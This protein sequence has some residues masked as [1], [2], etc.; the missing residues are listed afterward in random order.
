MGGDH[1]VDKIGPVVVLY[2]IGYIMSRV[3]EPAVDNNNP[4]LFPRP[5]QITPTNGNG[6]AALGLL[7]YTDEVY[8]V[9]HVTWASF[10]VLAC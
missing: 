8:L 5:K 7:T 10:A 9:S 2:V 1:S 4:L 3:A 6:V